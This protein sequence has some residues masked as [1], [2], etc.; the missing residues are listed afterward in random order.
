MGMLMKSHTTTLTSTEGA[1]VVVGMGSTGMSCTRYLLQRGCNVILM[2]TREL[3]PNIEQI[4]REFADLEQHFGG[5]DAQILNK[6]IQVVLSPGVSLHEPALVSAQQAGVEIIG[7]IELFARQA[8]A[9]VLAITGSNGKSTVTAMLAEIL[10]ADGCNVHAGGNLGPPALE[11]LSA[12]QADVFVLELSSF[13]LETTSSLECEAAA[14]LNLSPDHLDRYANYAAYVAAK[15]RLFAQTE[16]LI[17]NQDDPEV[18]AL[19]SAG[20]KVLGFSLN[21]HTNALAT[22]TGCGP[23]AW[24]SLAGEAVLPVA[25]LGVAGRHNHANALA[26]MALA[27]CLDVNTE[28]M[29]KALREFH[30]L[31]HRCQCVCRH[32]G[33]S[34]IND[35]KG[36]NVDATMAAIRGLENGRNLILIAGGDGK[37]QDFTALARLIDRHVQQLILIGR[38]A[39]VIEQ[40]LTPGQSCAH[41]GDLDEAVVLAEKFAQAGMIVLFSPACASFDMFRNYQ[42]RGDAFIEAVCSRYPA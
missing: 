10:R 20:R 4:H 29:A 35:S 31:A 30:G 1:V 25:E 40:A 41:A 26:A 32:H 5:L 39:P 12:A 24:L 19:D 38:D 37:Q 21:P 7:D 34:W 33:V 9:P 18:M 17:V 2:D 14:V 16:H 8:K 13:Q 23:E 15:A 27:S 36:T 3:P 28:S 42:A 6:A 11:L 22:R